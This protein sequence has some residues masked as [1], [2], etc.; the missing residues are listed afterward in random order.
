MLDRYTLA[1]VGLLLTDERRI[2]T[3][4]EVEVAAAKAQGAPDN[5]IR[6]LQGNSLHR[7]P[8]WREVM[9]AEIETGHDVAAFLRAWND[10]L[11]EVARPWLHRNMTSSDLVDTANALMMKRVGAEL[12]KESA[13]FFNKLAEHAEQHQ[14]TVRV[15][16]T[17]GQHAE[18]TTWGH[19]VANLAQA[20]FRAHR[21]IEWAV[22]NVSVAKL[23]GPVGDY[24][25]ISPEV[26]RTF[27]QELGLERPQS[28]TQILFRDTYADLVW[29]CSQAATVVEALALE[30][31]LGQQTELSE[32]REPRPGRRPVGSSAMPHK[33]NPITSEQ[34]CGLARLVRAQVGPVQEGVATW[35]ERDISHSSVERVALK[36]SLALTHYMLVHGTRL[37]SNLE[38]DTDRMCTNATSGSNEIL[39][40]SAARRWLVDNG[41]TDAQLAWDLVAEASQVTSVESRLLT[42]A[43]ILVTMRWAKGGKIPA[44]KFPDFAP[45]WVAFRQAMELDC[46]IGSN[47][48]VTFQ[49][50]RRVR[51]MVKETQEESNG[52][53]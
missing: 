42:D 4:C 1:S 18:I 13:Q 27:A 51:Q 2:K 5:V 8:T 49:T 52:V 24:K 26:E 38:V 32:L 6:I 43:V 22:H 21:R 37:I 29:A 50:L 39:L 17:H 15:G 36:Q 48:G 9:F 45:D 7:Q 10:H 33:R 44:D 23:S 25:A 30:V 34:L 40:S 35:H 47:D 3:W 14:F 20:A 46:Q 19:W 31:R 11:P 28:A 16:R 12:I 41:L 53:R